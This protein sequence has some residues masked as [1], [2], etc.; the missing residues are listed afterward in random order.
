MRDDGDAVRAGVAVG[1]GAGIALAT[2]VLMANY[3]LGDGFSSA[4]DAATVF[5]LVFGFVFLAGA[6]PMTARQFY[7]KHTTHRRGSDSAED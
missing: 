1:L 2:V 3:W 4:I 5:V 6:V 7:A